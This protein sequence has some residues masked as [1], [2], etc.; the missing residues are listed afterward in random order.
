MVS[1]LKRDLELLYTTGKRKGEYKGLDQNIVDKFK[2][3]V[4]IMDLYEKETDFW[5]IPSWR[6]ERLDH[7]YSSVRI[8][9]KYR[10][11]MKVVMAD[12]GIII[13]EIGLEEINNHYAK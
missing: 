2:N 7:G 3:M 10:L 13:E 12:D 4:S 8:N 9:D 1:F 5:S 11:I 6:Y